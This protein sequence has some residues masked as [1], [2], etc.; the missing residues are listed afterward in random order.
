MHGDGRRGVIAGVAAAERVGHDAF[1]QVAVG[2]APADPLVDG[3]LKMPVNV[4]IG[5]QLHKDAG[6]AGVLADG[7]VLFFGGGEVGPEQVEGVFRQRPGLFCPGFGQRCLH[8]FGQAGVGL[9]AEPGHGI[10]DGLCRNG[11][12]LNASSYRRATPVSRAAFATALATAS[13]TRGSKAPG[14]MFSSLRSASVMR[15]AMA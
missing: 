14:M 13:A 3:L 4:D 10:G 1:A 12:H 8:I 2:I 9:D 5:A 11:S 15:S 7:Q 6:H